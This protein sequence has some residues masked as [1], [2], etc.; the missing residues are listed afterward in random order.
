MAAPAVIVAHLKGVI[1]PRWRIFARFALNGLSVCRFVAFCGN[2][3]FYGRNRHH[4]RR[5][6]GGDHKHKT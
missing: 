4:Q 5:R 3:P 2:G 6:G 1:A